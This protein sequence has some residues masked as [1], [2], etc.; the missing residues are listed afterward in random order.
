MGGPV[1]PNHFDFEW[2]ERLLHPDDAHYSTRAD[3]YGGVR[4][5]NAELGG[6]SRISFR[7]G[8]NRFFG[9]RLTM[10]TV[11]VL[12]DSTTIPAGTA[13]DVQ[14]GWYQ[15]PFIG[16]DLTEVQAG[17]DGAPFAADALM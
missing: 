3:L 16:L 14:I 15:L 6:D 9:E 2:A 12:M 17:L 4:S 10:A 1:S 7:R 5:R 11:R 8:C 13:F